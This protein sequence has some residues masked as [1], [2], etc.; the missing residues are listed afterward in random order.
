MWHVS[1]RSG[2]ATLRTAIHLLLTYLLIFWT[3]W[4]LS[5]DS[6]VCVCRSWWWNAAG[7]RG[8]G[9]EFRA[10]SSNSRCCLPEERRHCDGDQWPHLIFFFFVA[11]FFLTD[12]ELRHILWPSDPVT[13]ES[14]DPETQL[15]RWPCSAMNSKCRLMCRGARTLSSILSSTRILDN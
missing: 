15:T 3:N 2:V 1:S 7:V 11:L 13:R 6:G 12:M 8:C 9:S 5:L 14:S 10:R 4:P